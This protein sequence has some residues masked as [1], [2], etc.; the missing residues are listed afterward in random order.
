VKDATPGAADARARGPPRAD[1]GPG[2][3]GQP[4]RGAADD[5]RLVDDSLRAARIV[6]RAG[7]AYVIHPL[8]DGVPRVDPAL[9][10][11]WCDWAHAQDDV[12]A[13]A[14]VLLAPEAMGVP[15]AVALSLRSGL[16]YLIVRKRAYD[17]PGETIVYCETGYSRTCLYLNGLRRE[18][19]VVIVDDILST[20][21]TMQAIVSALADQGIA[22]QGALV[23]AVK[24]DG[25]A[26]L[27]AR[28]GVPVRVMRRIAVA[29]GT[30]KIVAEE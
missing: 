24:G 20:G 30:V 11:A 22:V 7:Y 13:G 9:V 1:A 23:F 15:L 29:D 16:P 25:R 14:T 3:D 5:G 2:A 28:L 12:L 4:T 17:L 10:T 19:R 26:A 27:Q 8:T 21:G 18:D 6:D